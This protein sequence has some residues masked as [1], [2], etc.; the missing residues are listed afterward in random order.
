[1]KVKKVYQ[2][3]QGNWHIDYDTDSLMALALRVYIGQFLIGFAL[4]LIF[5]I[6]SIMLNLIMGKPILEIDG[7]FQQNHNRQER[8]FSPGMKYEK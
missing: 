8:L 6:S 2:D 1:M 4:L 5:L 3:E 7:N